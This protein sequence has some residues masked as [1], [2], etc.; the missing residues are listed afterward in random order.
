[1]NNTAENFD[2]ADADADASTS[3]N[4]PTSVNGVKSEELQRIVQR[5]ENLEGQKAGISEDIKLV[6]HEA[7]SEG[8]DVAAINKIIKLRKKDAS[9]IEAE[10]MIL[11][12][13][14]RAMGMIV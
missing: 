1:M 2:N 9:D 10:E 11:D 3:N 7:K 4:A 8:F 12:V 14:M 5:I 6:K 13:Y